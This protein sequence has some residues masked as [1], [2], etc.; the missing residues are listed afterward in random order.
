MQNFSCPAG[1][2]AFHYLHMLPRES[3][4]DL[5]PARELNIRQF[6]V[7]RPRI[8]PLLCRFHSREPPLHLYSEPIAKWIVE[9]GG[10]TLSVESIV[11]HGSKFEVRLPKL[12][13]GKREGALK[14]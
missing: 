11:G 1:N 5:L 14:A 7:F 6:E 4:P 8:L 13:N 12:Q 9:K 10:G 2:I 3:E